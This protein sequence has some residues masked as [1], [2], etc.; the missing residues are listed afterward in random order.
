MS[1]G[2]RSQRVCGWRGE[3]ANRNYF[4]QAGC[5]ERKKKFDCYIQWQQGCKRRWPF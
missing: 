4:D 3:L 2:C 5:K 1:G